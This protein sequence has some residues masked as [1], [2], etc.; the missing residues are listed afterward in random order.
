VA[1]SSAA[2]GHRFLQVT[3]LLVLALEQA[4]GS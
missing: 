3:V 1:A 4:I 2:S